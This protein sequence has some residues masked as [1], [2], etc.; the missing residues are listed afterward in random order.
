[1]NSL[2]AL[3]NDA[4]EKR[5]VSAVEGHSVVIVCPISSVPEATFSWTFNDERINFDVG[6]KQE[7]R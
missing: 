2:K 6:S 5:P 7:R 4:S 1:M 3:T